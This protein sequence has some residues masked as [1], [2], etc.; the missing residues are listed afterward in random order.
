MADSCLATSWKM[1]GGTI[2]TGKACFSK[3][4]QRMEGSCE[5]SLVLSGG[6]S[7]VYQHSAVSL[8][9][10]RQYFGSMTK[11]CLVI[12][13]CH[14]AIVLRLRQLSR[15]IRVSKHRPQ[16][17]LLPL[18]LILD[19]WYQNKTHLFGQRLEIGFPHCQSTS[20]RSILLATHL[21]HSARRTH[22]SVD[23]QSNRH[24]FSFCKSPVLVSFWT[25]LRRLAQVAWICPDVCLQRM[26]GAL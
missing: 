9:L 3:S 6:L 24:V 22:Y 12:D 4:G 5:P 1:P 7:D 21:L 18:L 20:S 26:M 13:V 19:S 10:S 17:A 25:P 11:A 16:L 15:H 23:R 14:S 2:S 8:K